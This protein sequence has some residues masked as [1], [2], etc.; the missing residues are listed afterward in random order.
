[1][2]EE[3]QVVGRK[4]LEKVGDEICTFMDFCDFKRNF[5]HVI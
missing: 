4:N 3:K 2:Q 5:F 1:M